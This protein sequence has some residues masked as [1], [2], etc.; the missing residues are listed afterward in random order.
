MLSDVAA[1]TAKVPSKRFLVLSVLSGTAAA[2][3]A[4]QTDGEL[5]ANLNSRLQ[6]R[7]KRNFVVVGRDLEM[8]D[9]CDGIH[10]VD[11]GYMKIAKAVFRALRGMGW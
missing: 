7:Y 10:L 4:T 2:E 9:Y 1:M 6:A 5:L 3:Q 8:A 11:S